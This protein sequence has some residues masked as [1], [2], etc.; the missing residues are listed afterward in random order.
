M[1]IMNLSPGTLSF[2][3]VQ[4]V[5]D[6][7]LYILNSYIDE[8]IK[9]FVEENREL[10]SQIGK[11]GYNAQETLKAFSENE[12]RLLNH[13]FKLQSTTD[14]PLLNKYIIL[15]EK[16]N[17][18]ENNQRNFHRLE[19][20]AQQPLFQDD[21]VKAAL[22][23][24]HKTM[25]VDSP[26]MSAF[27]SA[28]KEYS[29]LKEQFASELSAINL[30]AYD[31][32]MNNTLVLLNN[33]FNTAAAAMIT[34]PYSSAL[35]VIKSAEALKSTVENSG[36]AIWNKEKEI[37]RTQ[38]AAEKVADSIN[39][40]DSVKPELQKFV[41]ENYGFIETTPSREQ[42]NSAYDRLFEKFDSVSQKYVS[43]FEDISIKAEIPYSSYIVDV[44]KAQKNSLEQLQNV[45]NQ[46][47]AEYIEKQN[48]E[49]FKKHGL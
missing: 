32:N 19:N 23:K 16:F 39:S 5:S 13:R 33:Q 46:L 2:S 9:P 44:L 42:I 38:Y 11:I 37:S 47:K 6:R 40:F 34:T 24:A 26:E 18:F 36:I 49:F 29:K 28:S 43:K 31:K 30:A 14:N 41:D 25:S 27:A 4:N 1:K 8:K 7:S 48:A 15:E 35:D 45:I 3:S 10:F 22:E 20:L 21:R 12:K 17:Q